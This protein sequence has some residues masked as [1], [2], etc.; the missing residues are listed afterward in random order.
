MAH[1]FH[2][3]PRANIPRSSFDRTHRYM[4]TLDADWL[5]PLGWDDVMPGDTFS[6]DVQVFGR[7]ATALHPIM[8]N[9][10]LDVFHFFVPYRLLWDNWEKF[11]GA[12]DDPGDSIDYTVPAVGNS[13]IA[14]DPNTYPLLDYLGLPV[15]TKIKLNQISAFPTR[16]YQR[17]WAE[18]FRDQNL[19][20]SPTL[21]TGDGP[22]NLSWGPVLR[23][24]N[25][26]H[27]Y[28]TAALP[29][30]QKGDAVSLPLG[31]T[32]P[33][34]TEASGGAKVIVDD[35]GSTGNAFHL[36]IQTNPDAIYDPT[37]GAV[38]LVADLSTATAATI[39]DL[40]LAFQTQKLLER[41][42][43]S[44]TRYNE[45]ILAHFGVTVPDYRVQRPEYLGG[46]SVPINIHTVS[47]TAQG[48]AP[49]TAGDNVGDLAAFGTV[50]GSSGYT[51]SFTEHGLVMTLV[52]LRGEIT[53]SQ[54]IERKWSR[55]T[56][57][58]FFYPVLGMIGEQP[59]FKKEI[60]ADFDSGVGGGSEDVEVFGYKPAYEEYRFAQS[61]MT[62]LFSVNAASNLAPWHLGE[63][64]TSRPV[65]S[66]AFV[67]ANTGAPLDRA[68]AVPSEPHLILDTEIR[69]RCARPMPT[70]GV[71]GRLD[72]F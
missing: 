17:I 25:K 11:C 30:P 35:I 66:D 6:V 2:S 41:D 5:V 20:D 22:D 37:T 27:D 19:Q 71:P 8:D 31:T 23:K 21:A 32:A 1:S 4:T 10:F 7:I 67:T 12:Q 28:F 45:T 39:N 13:D 51:K 49:G 72:H 29:W 3:I 24:R 64:F 34:G 38:N 47:Q 58:D 62:G 68:I 42:A 48:P 36:D 60:Y 54:G 59:I 70:Y 69:M 15:N 61:R 55:R 40:R 65:L 57:F 9:M 33:V 18:W 43:R 56:R 44:G 16:A 46:G 14:I 26:R 52:N 50:S 63:E 53:Y